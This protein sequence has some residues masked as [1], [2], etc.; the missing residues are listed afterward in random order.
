MPPPKVKASRINTAFVL[1][2][3][4][5]RFFLILVRIYYCTSLHTGTWTLVGGVAQW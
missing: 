1:P 3:L 4:G 5:I 2:P